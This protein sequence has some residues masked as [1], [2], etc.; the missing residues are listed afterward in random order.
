MAAELT[1]ELEGLIEHHKLIEIKATQFILAC[2]ILNDNE[3]EKILPVITM[4]AIEKEEEFQGF[5]TKE[6]RLECFE[7]GM[8][9]GIKEGIK[10]GIVEGIEQT[11]IENA[12]N[13][14]GLLSDEIIA[15]KIGLPLERVKS[16]REQCSI[17]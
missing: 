13:L 4:K 16:L 1:N 15:E 11:K 14:L 10:E 8:E 12:Q 17:N 9:K 3:K 6:E 2:E 5:L 7:K